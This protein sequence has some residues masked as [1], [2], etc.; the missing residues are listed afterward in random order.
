MIYSKVK[1]V[2][3]ILAAGLVAGCASTQPSEET[4]SSSGLPAW[5]MMPA[6]QAG[7]GALATTECVAA[8]ANMSILKAKSISLGRAALAQQIQVSV[9]V[10]EETY[11]DM[12]ENGSESGSGSTFTSVSKQ[13]ADQMLNGAIPERMDYLDGDMDGEGEKRYLCTMVVLA[14]EKNQ[15]I[16][17]QIIEKANR[18]MTPDNEA[19]LYQEYRANRAADRLD[20]AMG[21]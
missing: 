6:S 8:N 2:T 18:Q 5:V 10:M 4:S 11:Q 14:P 17:E 16:F 3:A 19:L 1:L 20:Q 15:K 13:V 12:T 9:Q 21:R 7:E